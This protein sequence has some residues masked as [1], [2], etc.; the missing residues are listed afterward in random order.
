MAKRA[1]GNRTL[2]LKAS[3]IKRLKKQITP[4]AALSSLQHISDLIIHGDCIDA[5]SSL[6][7]GCIDLLIL[8]PPYNLYKKFNGR[9]FTKTTREKYSDWLDNHLQ[10][11]LPL[12]KETASVYICGDWMTSASIYD[13]ASKYFIVRNRITWEREKGRAA[14]SNWKNASEDIWYCTVSDTYTFNLDDVKLRR[15]VLA[16]YRTKS[17][18]PKDWAATDEGKF[19]ETAPS[20]IWTDITIPFW[21]MPENTDHPTQKSEKLTAKMILAS[22]NPG[23]LI[24]DPFAGSGTTPVTAKKLKRK[25]IGIEIDEQYCLLASLRLELAEKDMSIQGYTDGVFWERNTFSKQK[26]T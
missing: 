3:D 21:S 5:V 15:Q 8:D 24:L 26:K 17:G 19:R 11:L 4:K 12:L 25:Y 13:V 20:N 2:S 9:A 23:D 7:A 10:T 14:K 6:S 22:S 18:Q 1:P 16:P